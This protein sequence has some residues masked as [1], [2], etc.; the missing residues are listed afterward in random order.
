[1]EKANNDNTGFAYTYS[2]KEQAELKRI[3]EK[4][5]PPTEEEDKMTRLRRLDASV[6]N[7]AKAISLFFGVVGTLIIGTGMSLCM[8]DLGQNLGMQAASTMI[9]GVILGVAGGII[10]I[11]AYPVYNSI[12]KAK[13]KKLAPEIIRLSDEL[14]KR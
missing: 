12:V 11:L 5:T 13:R 14:M 4:Y 6:T 7:T 8:T 10:D 9:T 3:R 2:S 1:M